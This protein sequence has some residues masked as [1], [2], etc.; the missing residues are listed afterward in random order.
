MIK[1]K[2]AI[3]TGANGGIGKAIIDTFAK[4]GCN[5]WACAHTRSDE[6]QF[7]LKKI[8]KQYGVFAKPLFF[9]VSNL[10]EVKE[11]LK[12]IMGE[13][14]SIDILVNNAGIAQYDSFFA[15]PMDTLRHFLEVNY[16]SVMQLTQLIARR[17]NKDGASIVFLSSVAGIE[18]IRGNI[19][20][21]ASKAA[22]AHSVRVLSQELAPMNIRVNAVAPG[23]V[24]TPM[25]LKANPE[26]WESLV[27]QTCLKRDARPEEIATVICFLCSEMASYI[28]GQVIRVDGG[29][30]T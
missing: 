15:L 13:K 5:V 6:F 12:I 4:N 29:L 21:G 3:I 28:T 7:Y 25:K 10:S 26:E 1:G 17:M 23:M 11:S 8:E 14:K 2:N 19:A 18:A 20:Y 24:D 16:V 30:H 27:C 9:D 22:I